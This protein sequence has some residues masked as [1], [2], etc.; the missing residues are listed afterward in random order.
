M[1]L[2]II[3]H[4]EHYKQADGSI[5]G[6]GATI[7]EINH[8]A[9]QYDEV[10]HIAMLYNGTPPKS[11]LP[12][13]SENIKFIALPALGGK[14]L[15]SK[16]NIIK[17]IPKVIT[18]IHKELKTTDLFQFRAPTGIGVFLIPYFT[19]FVKTKGWYKYA[20]NWSQNNLSFTY[21]LQRYMLKHQKRIVTVNGVWKNQPKNIL[22]FENP[23]LDE[24]DRNLGKQII[25]NKKLTKTINFC[26]VG[27]LNKNKGIDK[28]VDVFK[29]LTDSRVGTLHIVGDGSL[30]KELEKKSLEI[31]AKVIFHGFVSKND[32]IAIYKDSHFILLPSAS[33]G[34]PKV[35]GE[36]MN[37][38][39]VPIVSDISC[40]GQY[41]SD[42]NGFL[43]KPV[44]RA[45]LS[46]NIQLGLRVSEKLFL[47]MINN[48]YNLAHKFT[49]NYYINQI[50]DLVKKE[51]E[52]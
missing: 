9:K 19:W 41:I 6:W 4:T 44:T 40:I 39:C 23:C 33:E 15:A 10:V 29:T 52:N 3:S 2:T 24:K 25:A 43:I 36:A 7:T 26:F 11:S 45:S 32:I 20:G 21:R 5:V 38:G 17:N 1:K 13:L 31:S 27:G 16:L 42:K 22:P 30:R 34:F 35:I 14:T 37:F 28:I 48:N 46:K 18:I 8:L 49:Y 47:E 51:I 50:Q 12:Y